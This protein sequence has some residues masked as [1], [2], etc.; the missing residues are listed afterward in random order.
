MRSYSEYSFQRY[1]SAKVT[2]DDRALN[3][4]VWGILVDHSAPIR[5]VLELG[6]GIGT[7]IE[8]VARWGLF[9]DSLVHYT[10]IDMDAGNIRQARAGLHS[11][12]LEPL[13]VTL[14]AIDLFAFIEREA[15]TQTW[16]L[17]IAHAV[18]DLLDLR[19]ALPQIMSL[20]GPG[21]LLYLTINFDGITAFEP[22]IDAAF[23]RH[24]EALYH[25]TMDQRVTDG[26]ASGDSRT[27]R[28]LFTHLQSL[29]V[30]ILAAGPSDWVVHPTGGAYPHDEAAFLHAIINTMDKALKDHPEIDQE[31][32]AAWIEQRH[33]QIEAATL[34]YIAHQLDLLARCPPS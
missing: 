23:D 7:M 27:G 30:D 16:D 32:F 8:R 10:A 3:R 29:G 5:R 31:R 21:G 19:T 28:H 22:Q 15:G 25:A 1:L 11:N 26:Q 14:E 17:I 34:T 9:D 13:S 24:V 12:Q 18:L 33:Q 4:H 2:V 20:A 6:A